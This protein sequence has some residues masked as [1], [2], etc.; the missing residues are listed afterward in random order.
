MVVDGGEVVSIELHHHCHG[1]AKQLVFNVLALLD[2]E[3]LLHATISNDH[4]QQ[5]HVLVQD[6]VKDA[7]GRIRL[8]G[9]LKPQA[10]INIG[11][12]NQQV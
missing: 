4:A 10:Q 5:P 7:T 6:L 8:P 11:I 2:R 3:A 1:W 9:L 12:A